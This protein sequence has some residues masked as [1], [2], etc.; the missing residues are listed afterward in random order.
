[1]A[2]SFSFPAGRKLSAA[3]TGNTA[4]QWVTLSSMVGVFALPGNTPPTGESLLVDTGANEELVPI[5]NT[6]ATRVFGVFTKSHVLNTPVKALGVFAQGLLKSSTPTRLRLLGAINN[7]G[8][9]VYVEY[10]CSTAAG[11]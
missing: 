7:D 1:Q 8:N 10:V 9:L 6:D 4:A 5:T 2:G 11:T 3:V